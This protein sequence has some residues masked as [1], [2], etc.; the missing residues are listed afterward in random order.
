MKTKYMGINLRKCKAT[1]FNHGNDIWSTTTLATV[2]LL[3]KNAMLIPEQTANKYLFI[4]SFTVSENQILASFE[5]LMTKNG[6][7]HM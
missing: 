2:E 1:I 4:D 3:V 5:R 6:K 7:W